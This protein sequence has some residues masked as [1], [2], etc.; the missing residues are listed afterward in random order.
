[1]PN[2]SKVILNGT[3]LMDVTSATATA[4]KIISPYTAMLADGV[5]TTGTGSRDEGNDRLP[6][7]LDG[8]LSGSISDNTIT[9]LT[10]GALRECKLITDV[11]FPN[12]VTLGSNVFM[13]CNSLASVYLPKANGA[14][15]YE[16][17]VF[18]G[19]TSLQKI[20]LPS[21]TAL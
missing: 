6:S 14:S 1:M 8:S 12:V 9:K 13:G 3:T 2:V 18:K 17:S 20:A 15:N 11:S 5:M 21:Y 19:C 16:A 10:A 7:R 4:D